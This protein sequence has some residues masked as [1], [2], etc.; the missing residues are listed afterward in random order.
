MAEETLTLELVEVIA[1][2]KLTQ[3]AGGKLGADCNW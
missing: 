3:F 1:E 2:P